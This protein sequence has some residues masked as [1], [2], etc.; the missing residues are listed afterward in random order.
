MRLAALLATLTTTLAC[1]A[2][3]AFADDREWRFDVYLEDKPIGQQSFRLIDEGTRQRVIIEAS[4]DVKF[5]FFTAYSY[6]HQNEELWE[7]GCLKRIRSSTDD[8][9]ESFRLDG[10]DRGANFVTTTKSRRTELGDCVRSFAYWNPELLEADRLLNS[11]TG[12]YEAATLTL[13]ADEAKHY[14]LRGDK[15]RIELWYSPDG[16]WIALESASKGGRKLRYVR[17]N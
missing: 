8:N 15:F 10:E 6:R 5:L 16:D 1:L 17:S 9:G 4:F 2:G 13:Q 11:Q 3:A 14:L 7:D 12:E